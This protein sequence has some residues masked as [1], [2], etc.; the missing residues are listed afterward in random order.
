MKTNALVLGCV[1]LGA[2]VLVA[3]TTA[4]RREGPRPNVLL[5]T[6][7]SLRA[8][9]LDWTTGGRTPALASLA[10]RG[11]RFDRAY[12]VTPWT[13]PSLVSIF[14][15]L[16]PTTHGV[17]NRDDTTP[18]TLPTLPRILGARGYTLKNYG[19]FTAVSYYR[20][21]G[22]S[23][24]AVLGAETVGSERLADWLGSAPE[25]FFAWIHYAEPHMPYGASGYEA[26]EAKVKGSS[27]L[28]RAQVAA[29]VPL[30][31][32]YA[33]EAGDR[34]KLLALYDADVERMDA[35]I[36]KVLAALFARGLADRTIVVFTA[37]HGEELLD[38][39]WVGH[40]ST[41]GEAKLD[42]EVLRIPLVFAGPGIPAARVTDAL[43]QNVDV[44]PTVLSIAGA[45]RPKGMQGVSLTPAFAGKSPRRRVYFE[46]SPGGHLTPESRKAERLEGVGDG[47]RIHAERRGAAR[48]P[49]DPE[50]PELAG[51]LET[52]RE[53][54]ARAR[55]RALAEYGGAVWPDP[56]RVATW[57]ETLVV[58]APGEGGRLTFRNAEATIRLAWDGPRREDPPYWV[59]YRIGSG[60]LSAS[61]AFGVE[62]PILAFGPF[63]LAFWNDLAGYSPFRFRILDPAGPRRSAWREFQLMPLKEER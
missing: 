10:A 57:P 35:E 58:S 44:T 20:N 15:G 33:F 9:R 39:G 51:D 49:S 37:D 56:A 8:D 55:L 61:G 30:G 63:P 2:G 27:G 38:H 1:L 62:D 5:M 29:S 53:H 4:I 3:C 34:E 60:I 42:E 43:A 52:W 21:L 36:G 48:E 11:I 40:A 19:F 25:P 17:V 6:A 13:A 24:Q 45:A 59:E 18:K 26:A 31:A 47:T 46:T 54:Q 32:G 28:E 50:A 16:Y 12:T 14:T 41:S 23:E 22:L 7:D